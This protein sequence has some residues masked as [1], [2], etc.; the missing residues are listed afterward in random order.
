M[1][2]PVKSLRPRAFTLIELLVVIAII[3]ILAAILFPV[4]AQAREK[5]R[6]TACLSNMKQ[7]G[8]GLMMYVQDF[9]EVFPGNLLCVPTIN[10]GSTG[11]TRIPIDRQIAPYTKNDQIFTCPS[12]AV[13]RVPATDTRLQ[14]W[15]GSYRARGIRRSYSYVGTIDTTQA[16]GRE[17]NTGLSTYVGNVGI[18]GTPPVG[19]SMAQIDRPSE[20]IGLIENWPAEAT[21]WSDSAYVGSP[22]GSGFIGCDLWKL[23]GRIP[24][25]VMP[26]PDS[27]PNSCSGNRAK[28][29]TVG[30]S[31]GSNYV[32]CDGSA[33]YRTYRQ[34]RSNDFY[35]FK[36]QK[37]ATTFTP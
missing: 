31:L 27:L 10:G 9:D 7:I 6:Q 29:P 8:L 17:A 36:L 2:Q 35:M 34:V 33:K 4:F 12:D 20:T 30:H 18:N 13:S 16:N 14:Y 23:A 25:A 21:S 1:Y 26:A 3:A 19:R 32:L 24:G 5:A 28:L 15:D 37:P 22:H 11:D